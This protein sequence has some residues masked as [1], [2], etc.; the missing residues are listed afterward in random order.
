MV[1]VILAEALYRAASVLKGHPYHR[2]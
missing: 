2:E 1:R